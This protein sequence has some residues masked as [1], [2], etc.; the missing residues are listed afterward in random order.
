MYGPDL[1][2]V[3]VRDGCGRGE[4]PQWY[5]PSGDVGA[6]L[7]TGLWAEDPASE[8]NRVFVSTADKPHTAKGA[9]G[10]MKLTPDL[11][12]RTG[13][14]QKAWNPMYLELTVVGCLSEKALADAGRSDVAPD[15]PS[16]WA[17]IAHQLR[18]HDD[19]VPLATP[20]PMHLARLAADYVLPSE[21]DQQDD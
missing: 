5:A 1:R 13:P 16:T 11:S 3:L 14:G 18:S 8:D 12:G 7:S 6:G 17:T 9:K 4:V 21:P 10:V 20:L 15:A 2:L 19:Y